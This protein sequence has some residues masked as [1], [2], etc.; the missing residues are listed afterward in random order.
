MSFWK[1]MQIVWPGFLSACLLEMIFFAVFD[2]SQMQ[3]QF[4]NSEN[5]TQL[6]YT[7]SFFV[8][9]SATALSSFISFLLMREPEGK[10][11]HSKR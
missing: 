4:I 1:L 5:P 9:W 7:G 6:I 11:Q 3:S 10:D 2:P 8:F